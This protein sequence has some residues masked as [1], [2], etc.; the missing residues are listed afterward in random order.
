MPTIEIV[1]ERAE[2]ADGAAPID[3]ATLMAL[4]AGDCEVIEHDGAFALV[5][6]EELTLVVDPP[7]RRHGLGT[8]LLDEV[9]GSHPGINRA[10]SHG[11]HPAAARLAARHGMHRVR[12]LWVMRRELTSPLPVVKPPYGVELR[13]WQPGDADELLRVNAAAFA[14]HPEQ[15]QMDAANLAAR[16]AEPWFDPAGLIMAFET[17]GKLLGFH[18]TKQH[19]PELGEVYVVGVDPDAQGRGLGRLLT[20]AGLAHLQERGAEEVLLYVEAD[21][22]PAI[23]TYAGLG[24]THAAADTHVMYAKV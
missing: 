13:G 15:G 5:H 7:V 17:D 21:N 1:A 11:N 16:M 14:K 4:H 8:A 6:G 18:W 3:E 10:W 19:S 24:F 23:A 9:M 20:L 22:Q 12:D 2:A